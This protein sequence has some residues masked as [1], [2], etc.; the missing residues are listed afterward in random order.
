MHYVTQIVRLRELYRIAEIS[1]IST[2]EQELET[3][4][5]IGKNRFF[6][7]WLH[8]AFWCCYNNRFV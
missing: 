1:A 4:F 7:G 2:W 6:C 5:S 3:I 8:C